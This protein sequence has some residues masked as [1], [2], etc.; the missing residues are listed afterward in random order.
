MN[1]DRMKE[2]LTEV[3]KLARKHG[4]DSEQV[5]TFCKEHNDNEEFLKIAATLLFIMDDEEANEK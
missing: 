1:D 5:N 4:P 2:L 3:I